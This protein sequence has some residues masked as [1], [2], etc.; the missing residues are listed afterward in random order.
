MGSSFI[1]YG[2]VLAIMLLLGQEWLVRRNKSQ[3]FFD[4]A[5][6]G[7]WGYTFRLHVSYPR[8]VNTFTE[9][10]FGSNWSHKDLQHTSMGSF[11]DDHAYDRNHLV[12]CGYSRSIPFLSKRS[13]SKK[14][15]SC[16]RHYSHWLG[17]VFPPSGT[18]ILHQFARNFWAYIDCCGRYSNSRN[19]CGSARRLECR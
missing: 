1:A 13:T 19:H 11:Q 18:R 2:A 10:R 14:Y 17:N 7:A 3:E 12:L 8:L 5:V 15:R 6:I 4:S 16:N 9:H